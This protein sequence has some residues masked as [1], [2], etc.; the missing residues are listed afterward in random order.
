MRC[1]GSANGAR[2]QQ[3]R[4]KLAEM[5]TFGQTTPFNE[6]SWERLA[7]DWS[8]RLGGA[9]IGHMVAIIQSVIESGCT[10]QLAAASSMYDLIVAER[11][12]PRPA[13]HGRDRSLARVR[14][15]PRRKAWL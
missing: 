6:R 8:E 4:R 2:N 9:P 11:P 12:N 10:S 15:N 14:E 13:V 3:A 1:D 5:R 7:R